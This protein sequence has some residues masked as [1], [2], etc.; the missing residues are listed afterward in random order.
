MSNNVSLETE[1]ALSNQF[2]IWNCQKSR[3]LAQEHLLLDRENTGNLKV[4]FE[5]G[6]LYYL[7]REFILL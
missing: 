6:P 4:E 1:Y 2:Y 3:K 5:C 7:Q